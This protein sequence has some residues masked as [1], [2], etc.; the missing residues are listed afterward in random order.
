MMRTGY[1]IASYKGKD[2]GEEGDQTKQEEETELTIRGPTIQGDQLYMAVC[3]W[4][5]INVTFPVYTTVQW[6]TLAS[7]FTRYQNNTTMFT[8]RALYEY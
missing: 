4:Y 6:R 5:L 8:G 2:G 1:R 7:I 3:F